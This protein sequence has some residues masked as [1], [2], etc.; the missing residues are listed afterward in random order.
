M[1]EGR[2]LW[3]RCRACGWIFYNNPVPAANALIVRGG[4]LLLGRRA[5]PPYAGMWDTPGGFFEAGEAAEQALRR[6][7]REELGATPGRLRWAGAMADRYGRDG[8]PVLSLFFWVTLAPGRLRPADDV[9]ELEW[10]AIDRLPYTR[11]AFPS[12]RR[13][14]RGLF[15]DGRG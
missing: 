11:I 4:R 14:L 5:R 2:Q 1:R 10:F 8:F 6:E 9:S 3:R 12:T 7:L 13:L 15:G